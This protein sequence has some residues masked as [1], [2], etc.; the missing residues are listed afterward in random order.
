[1]SQDWLVTPETSRVG[2]RL[3]GAVPLERCD[4][5]ELASEGVVLG[6]I[7]VPHSGQPVL[8]L[9]DHPLTGGYPVI[10]VVE[11]HHLDLAG[12]IPMGAKIRFNVVAHFDPL[13]RN[14]PQ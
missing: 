6:A 2:A 1:M 4:T 12:Q 5:T 9:A 14:V 3:F 8:F 11:R 13:A 7:Q 10:A